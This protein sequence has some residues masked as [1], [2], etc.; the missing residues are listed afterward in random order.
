MQKTKILAI[1]LLALLLVSVRF[2]F[3]EQITVE[4][5][6]GQSL[7]PKVDTPHTHDQKV[8]NN[9]FPSEEEKPV[10]KYDPWHLAT[11][12]FKASERYF[13]SIYRVETWREIIRRVAGR[14]RKYIANVS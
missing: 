3:A 1:A 7:E 13:D 2:T 5:E 6:K 14:Y 10:Q 4:N 11:D 8:V 9:R 12:L